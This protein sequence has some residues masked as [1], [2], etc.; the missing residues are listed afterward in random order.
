MVYNIDIRKHA[1]FYIDGEEKRQILNRNFAFRPKLKLNIEFNIDSPYLTHQEH[2]GNWYRLTFKNVA[3]GEI[4]GYYTIEFLIE[5]EQVLSPL[6][7]GEGL[8]AS[9]NFTLYSIIAYEHDITNSGIIFN[10]E[11]TNTSEN[12]ESFY[13]GFYNQ[14]HFNDYE[15]KVYNV[16]EDWEINTTN[17]ETITISN[18]I[19]WS[20][21]ANY[22]SKINGKLYVDNNK[23]YFGAFEDNYNKTTS[24]GL[25]KDKFKYKIDESGSIYLE[26]KKLIGKFKAEGSESTDYI[27]IYMSKGKQQILENYS[28]DTY[29]YRQGLTKVNEFIS[30]PKQKKRFY[31]NNKPIPNDYRDFVTT[32]NPHV[33]IY[34]ETW[35]KAKYIESDNQI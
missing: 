8:L 12:I 33:N 28:I 5:T 19:G 25:S 13:R 16:N 1:L 11:A 35:K 18:L 29:T 32:L 6:T 10:Y 9:D 2:E 23:Y 24:Y 34:K 22:T 20:Q 7:F 3:N 27:E 21:S 30:L 14:G 17:P 4:V 15:K 26:E 31:I